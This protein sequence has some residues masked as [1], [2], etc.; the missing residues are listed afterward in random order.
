MHIFICF[1]F[2]QLIDKKTGIVCE[3]QQ[4]FLANLR[5]ALVKEGH[6]VFLAHYREKWGKELMGPLECTVDDFRQM[7]STDLVI[8]FPGDPISGGVHIELGWASAL[9]KKIVMFLKDGVEYSPLILGLS[10]VTETDTIYYKENV[11]ETME[12]ILTYATD[13]N[14]YEQK[15]V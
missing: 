9:N 15:C 5:M 7:K 1:P 4:K 11:T 3:E 14:E 10:T 8:A 6:E 12:K 2:S 13:R